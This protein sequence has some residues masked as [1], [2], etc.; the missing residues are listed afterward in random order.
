MTTKSQEVYI[1]RNRVT[2]NFTTL[3]NSIFQDKKLGWNAIGLLG[4]LLHFP[5]DFKLKL[6][7]LAKE[8]TG[9]NGRDSTRSALKMLEAAGY[10][11]I[12]KERDPQG[13]Y[14]KTTWHVSDIPAEKSPGSGFPTVDNPTSGNPTT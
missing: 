2:A 3:P 14:A 13:R 1:V 10:L 12:V 4:F 7:N 8:K 6:Y 5:P 9:I 11:R